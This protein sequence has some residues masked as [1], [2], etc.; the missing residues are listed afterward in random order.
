M[1]M[2]VPQARPNT[3]KIAEEQVWC[4]RRRLEGHTTREIATLSE[5]A[6]AVGDLTRAIGE[7]TVRRRIKMEIDSRVTPLSAELRQLELDKLDDLA[8]RAYQII[9]TPHFVLQYGEPVRSP[10]TGE[11]L[12]DDSP[13]LAAID[14][15]LKVA[16][17]RAKLCGLDAPVQLVAD[18]TVRYEVVGIDMEKML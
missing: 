5:A 11:Y 13:V 16:E 12:I 7:T 14:R 9:G 1:S 2:T 10:T 8:R 17:R 3:A 18:T 15:L 4:Y 6:A